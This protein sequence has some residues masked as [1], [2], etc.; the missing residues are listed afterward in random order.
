M[1]M[2]IFDVLTLL[3]GLC[4]FLFG[5][6]IMGQ[7]LERRAGNKL[8]PLLA[9]MTEHKFKGFLTG[10]GI[11]SIIQ[12]SSATTV[13][14]VGFVNSGLMTLKQATNVIIGANV[15][16]T[17]TGWILSLTGIRGDNVWVNMLKPS[18][19]VPI[20]ALLGIVMLMMSKKQ[21]SKDTGTILL[22]FATLM[23]GMEA[24]SNAVSGLA[25][26]EGFRNPFPRHS[27]RRGVDLHNSIE[28]RIRRNFA[29]SFNNGAGFDRRFRS[30]SYGRRHRDVHNSRYLF[31]RR[32][33]RSKESGGHTPCFQHN[34]NGFLHDLF[35]RCEICVP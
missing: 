1:N 17:V 12:S 2:D 11:T 21:K 10:L 24:M 30:H 25:E 34:R 13:M 15:G 28:F 16:T 9:K 31:N 7:A 6:N 3:G 26:I 35:L 8:R 14:V 19:F 23:F 33:A 29:G 5:M 20:L 32:K 27:R 4:L 18:S 22:G